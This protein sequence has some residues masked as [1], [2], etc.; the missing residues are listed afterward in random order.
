MV[1]IAMGDSSVHFNRKTRLEK[2]AEERNR[3]IKSPHPPLS[4]LLSHLSRPDADLRKW[5]AVA[6]IGA[7]AAKLAE[8]DMEHARNIV[9]RLMWMLNDESGGAG[10]GAPEAMGETLARSGAL[11]AEYAHILTSFIK[12]DGN[13]IENKALQRGV[14]W[15]IGRLAQVEPKLVKDAGQHLA[16]FLKSD[17]ASL[18]GLAAWI[19][20][21]IRE[22]S[23]RSYLE[24]LADDD[25]EFTLF[26][27]KNLTSLRVGDMARRALTDL[28]ETSF[29]E[30]REIKLR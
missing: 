18:R 11:A 25:S 21:L 27:E 10:W 7:R 28:R 5:Q 15:G 1:T 12:K 20:G 9:R 17:D 8:K 6:E 29:E 2:H 23:V 24:D 16:P 19:A 30:Q 14:L 4:R 26:L 22:K 3:A 13:Y